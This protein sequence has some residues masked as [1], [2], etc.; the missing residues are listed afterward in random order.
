[1]RK[2]TK[3]ECLELVRKGLGDVNV[4]Q[5]DEVLEVLN[6]FRK[7]REEAEKREE[8]EITDKFA[9]ECSLTVTARQDKEKKGSYVDVQFEGCNGGHDIMLLGV[10]ALNSIADHFPHKNRVDVIAEIG[11]LALMG[12][13]AGIHSLD[14]E[15]E[16]EE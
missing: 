7:E 16:E 11:T 15:E 6:E 9:D 3:E 1:M 12:S 14:E 8:K 4:E 5:L 10:A 2:I 13:M